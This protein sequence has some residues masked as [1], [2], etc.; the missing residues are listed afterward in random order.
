MT[1]LK[2]FLV[3]TTTRGFAG[4]TVIWL[5]ATF[6]VLMGMAASGLLGQAPPGAWLMPLLLLVVFA[7]VLFMGWGKWMRER[8]VREGPL[9]VQAKRKLRAAFV[10]MSG[11]DA[12]LAE[13]AL[14]QFFLAKVRSGTSRPVAMPSKL[15]ERL[16][17][18]FAAD[19]DAYTR[20][21]KLAFGRVIAPTPTL[22]LGQSEESN[23]ALR[24]T[25]FWACKEEAINPKNPTRLPLLFALDAK[26]AVAGGIIYANNSAAVAWMKKHEAQGDTGEVYLGTSFSGNG[27]S[28]D[29]D[30]FGGADSSSSDGG[31]GDSGSGGDGGGGDGGGGGD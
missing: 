4:V 9:P 8:F 22:S 31:S 3:R 14:R 13:R 7:S 1:A 11:K 18:E 29:C 5:A 2:W 10:G 28:G 25:W 23:D 17:R 21:C 12:D 26:L 6:A 16:W 19:T 30:N 20:W 24:R 27:Y 15:A